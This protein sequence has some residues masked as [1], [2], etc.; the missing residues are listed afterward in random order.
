MKF[1]IKR[2]C[3]EHIGKPYYIYE[4]Y[5]FD[6]DPLLSSDATVLV[7]YIQLAVDTCRNQVKYIFGY[8]P[9]VHWISMNLAIPK[10]INGNLFVEGEI[11]TGDNIRIVQIGAWK[12]YFDE[13]SGWV[14]VGD[15]SF[16]EQDMA[17]KFAT[18]TIS[19]IR[20]GLLRS[21]W[22]KPIFK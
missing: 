11:E 10:Y 4:D 3:S 14:C 20:E 21:L 13:N 7:E 12:T 2:N 15:P 16:T 18:D 1:S 5:S 19:V 17:V 9:N 8:H 22:V 6:Y